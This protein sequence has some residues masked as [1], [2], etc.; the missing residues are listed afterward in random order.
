MRDRQ[1]TH[2]FL[3]IINLPMIKAQDI[4]HYRIHRRQIINRKLINL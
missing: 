4:K 2:R 3:I 1:I